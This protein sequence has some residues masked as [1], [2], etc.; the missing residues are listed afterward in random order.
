MLSLICPDVLTPVRTQ[1]VPTCVLVLKASGS[2]Q[3]GRPVE[4]NSKYLQLPFSYSTLDNMCFINIYQLFKRYVTLG[5]LGN[6]CNNPIL[7]YLNIVIKA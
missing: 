3:M 5:V 2:T 7:L 4:V 1:K 6:M